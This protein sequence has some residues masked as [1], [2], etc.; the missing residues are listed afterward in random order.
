MKTKN[1]PA[2]KCCLIA[3]SLILLLGSCQKNIN[4]VPATPINTTNESDALFKKYD[5]PVA[6]DWYRLQLR[7]LLKKNSVLPNGVLFGYIGIGLYESV[8]SMNPNAVS[9]SEKL[10]QMPA[11]PVKE[12]GKSYNWEVS[13]N[14]AMAD[15]VRSFYKGITTA[16]SASIDSLE[17]AYNKKSG[18]DNQDEFL[19][20]QSFGKS[21]ATAV[22]NWYLTDN[23]NLT[24]TGYVPPVFE[25]AWIPTPPAFVNPPVLPFIGSA[26]TYL[27]A[28]MNAVAPK[29]PAVYSENKNSGYYKIAKE[30]YDVSKNLTDEQ[31]NIAM[32]WIDQGDGVG[33]TPPG[34]NQLIVTQVIEQEKISLLKAAEAYAKAGI[35][36]RESVVVCFRSKYKYTTMRP[37]SY[38]KKVIDTSWMPFISTPPHPEYPAAHALNTGAVMQAVEGVLGANTGFT[39]HAYDFRGWPPQTFASLFDAARQAGISRLYGGIHYQPSINTGLVIGKAI[40]TRISAIKLY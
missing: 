20:S 31:K 16:D 39:D 38:I 8:R 25:G 19:R 1:A 10:Y 7:F 26:R 17:D 29:Y 4:D 24:N 6:T 5:A 3:A 9:F 34:H 28:D 32:F 15:L 14:A 35:A 27:A 23:I 11:M 12:K 37:V 2:V 18:D 40:G 13:A 36:E 21:I 30:V 33:Y 22:Y